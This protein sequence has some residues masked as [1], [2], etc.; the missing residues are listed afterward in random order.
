M[1][2]IENLSDLAAPPQPTLE[3]EVR[4]HPERFR[5]LTGDRPTGPLHLGHYLRH[6][7]QPRPPAASSGVEVFL[8][9]ADYQVI[10]DRDGVGELAQTVRGLVLD[11]LA[12]A[13]DPA[14]ATIFAHSAV[15]ALNQ[16]L[17]PFLGLVSV[18]EL[19]RNP[20][21]KAEVGGPAAAAA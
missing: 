5:V 1:S 10:T 21:V 19:Q 8:V 14:A 17:L 16:L 11:Y 9:I 3:E 4:R 7:R 15:P 12:A 20:T 13:I 2:T 6:A 18:A